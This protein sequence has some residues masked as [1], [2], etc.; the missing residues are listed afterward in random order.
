MQFANQ[1]SLIAAFNLVNIS[2][3]EPATILS[4][5]Q[6]YQP[7]LVILNLEWSQVIELQLITALRLDW[8]TRNIPILM[9]GNSPASEETSAALDYDAYLTKPYSNSALEGA[10]YSLIPTSDLIVETT[11]C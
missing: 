4:W 1:S 8:L 3:S 11:D 6:Q 10:I 2:I 9:L 7:D 5:V